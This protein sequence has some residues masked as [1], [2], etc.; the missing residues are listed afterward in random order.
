M[1]E[2]CKDCTHHRMSYGRI[3]CIAGMVS[4]PV[5]NELSERGACGPERLLFEPIDAE[6]HE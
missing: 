6:S 5:E 1:I 3:L 2:E 4:R